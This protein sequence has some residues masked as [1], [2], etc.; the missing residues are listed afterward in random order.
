MFRNGTAVKK[1]LSD[2]VV[3]EEN[4]ARMPLVTI[5]H[6]TLCRGTQVGLNASAERSQEGGKERHQEE[7]EEREREDYCDQIYNI[8]TVKILAFCSHDRSI[9]KSYISSS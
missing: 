3:R 6:G 1:L 5:P 8:A 7:E 2:G 9:A 4:K